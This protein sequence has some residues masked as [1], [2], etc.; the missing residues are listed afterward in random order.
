MVL[1]S[2]RGSVDPTAILQLE[3]LGQLKNPTTSPRMDGHHPACSTVAQPTTLPCDPTYVKLHVY[4]EGC[5]LQFPWGQLL[6]LWSSESIEVFYAG[7]NISG[8]HC[9]HF[10]G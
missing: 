10:H 2:V 8:V 3:G 4:T 5:V 7:T 9:L 6:T 1:V